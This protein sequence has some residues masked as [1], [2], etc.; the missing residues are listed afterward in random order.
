MNKPWRS[1][2]TGGFFDELVTDRGSPRATT[3]RAVNFFGGLSPDELQARRSAAELA[4]KE[5]GISF[6]VHT[7]EDNIDRAWPYDMIPRII[8]AREWATLSRGLAQRTRALNCFI[9]DI[10][11]TADFDR[12][13]CAG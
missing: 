5:M 10:Q 1:Y 3:R 11:P 9:D 2:R 7:E 13:Y 4:V 6:T 12:R 8:S